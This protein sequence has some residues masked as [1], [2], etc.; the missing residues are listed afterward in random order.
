VLRR[1][2][3]RVPPVIC[4][5]VHPREAGFA[6]PETVAYLMKPVKSARL[7]AALASA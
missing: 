7:G 4:L 1:F 3:E 5:S 6:P 2:A